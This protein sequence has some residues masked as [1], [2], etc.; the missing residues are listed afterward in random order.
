MKSKLKI[1]VVEP[2][3]LCNF[4][5]PQCPYSPG[6]VTHL[7]LNRY[8]SLVGQGSGLGVEV[9][10]LLGLGEPTLHPHFD[11]LLSI[12]RQYRI[13]SH[14]LTNG[15]FVL[16]H[17]RIQ[18]MLA[19]PPDELEFSID[20]SS[21]TTFQAVR[22]K[23]ELYFD[24]LTKG[25]RRFLHEIDRAR[26]RLVVSFV[27]HENSLGEL[28][29]FRRQWNGYVDE[30]RVRAPHNFNGTLARSHVFDPLLSVGP[31]PRAC[32]FWQDRIAMASTGSVSI[33]NLDQTGTLLLAGAGEPLDLEH[34]WYRGKRREF[35]RKIEEGVDGG[36]CA[37]CT[38][39]SALV[40]PQAAHTG[41]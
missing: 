7:R 9:V 32:M 20:A 33:C 37:D 25:I 14:V 16:D 10:R 31:Q 13:R 4:R 12:A 15:S 24:R 1:L 28:G 41:S 36:V 40:W 5:C 17:S 23:D 2:T 38:K 34:L 27:A 39:C 26:T 35:I 18:L 22:G 21:A 11:R 19:A 8:E 6:R 3:N 30:V 29:D